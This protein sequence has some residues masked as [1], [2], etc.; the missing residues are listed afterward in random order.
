MLCTWEFRGYHR[1]IHPPLQTSHGTWSLREGII[2]RLQQVEDKLPGS[3]SISFGEIAPIPWF[4]SETLATAIDLCRQLPAQLSWS[5]IAAIPEQFSACQFGFAS[6]WQQLQTP[7]P[8]ALPRL[9]YA[10]LLPT[11]AA[12]LEAWVKLWQQGYRTFKW[13]IGV[14]PI[15][16]ELQLYQQL[17]QLLPPEA[18]LRLDANGGLDLDST[19]QWLQVC[20]PERLEFI[21]Q[22]LPPQE[23][24]KMQNLAQNSPIPL[25]LDESVANFAQFQACVQRGWPGIFVIKPAIFGFP[26]RLEQFCQENQSNRPLDLVFSSALEG[27]IG[28]HTSL[29]LAA[30][31]SH[32][33]RAVGFGTDHWLGMPVSQPSLE[34]FS[35]LWQELSPF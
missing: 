23:F 25:A 3:H 21:E 8:W 12:A 6:A 30:K 14:A 27:P 7:Q 22:P 31:L 20:S 24:T 2:L 4:G 5:E 1:P 10:G 35:Q 17:C 9:S 26:Q 15:H 29:H 34:A 11:G 32:P 19:H 33:Y 28:R 13:K 18:K 16:T